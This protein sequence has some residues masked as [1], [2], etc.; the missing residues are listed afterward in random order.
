MAIA[1][2]QILVNSRMAAE[3][4]RPICQDTGI[5]T[6]F[7]KVGMDVR[8]DTDTGIDGM[9]NQA[10]HEAY[11]DPELAQV[12]LTE[13]QARAAMTTILAGDATPA[14]LIAFVVALR[15]KGE[16]AAELSGLLDAVGE[17]EQGGH[18]LDV[19]VP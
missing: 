6:A 17:S 2:A 8:W 12:G 9:V 10:V 13:D 4:H 1:L 16:S 15:A 7:L 11:T 14:Q 18:G 3:G 19:V 5:V